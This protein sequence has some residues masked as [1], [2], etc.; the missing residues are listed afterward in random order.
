M[1]AILTDITKCVGCY[2][3]V[4][5]CKK[6]NE[7]PAD[8][9]RFWQKNDGLS[10]RNWTSVLH[11]GKY[12]IRKHCQHCIEPNCVAVCPV[13]ALY[14]TET[15]AVIYDSAKCLGCRYCMMACPYGIP[16]YDWDSTVPYIKKCIMC[17][18]NIKN[19]LIEQP[20]C[21]SA[22]PVNATIYGEREDLLSIAKQRIKDNPSL[23]MNHVYGEKEVGGTN[24]LYITAKDCPL[25]FLY[26]YNKRVDK[27]VKL[28][29]QPDINKPLPLTTKLAMESV[30][31]AF[32]GM[33]AIMS[34][35][36]WLI[37]RREKLSKEKNDGEEL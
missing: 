25:D 37:K 34:G 15:G 33:G 32:L 13:G 26:Y 11:D 19:G 9:P 12:N 6:I 23:Y 2:R 28:L 35:A 10:A 8:K 17:Y 21:I 5:A 14:K 36:Y 18:E 1:K 31:F 27:N 4:K 29:G 16:R 20:A 30:P 22:C 7:L 24:V 3:C